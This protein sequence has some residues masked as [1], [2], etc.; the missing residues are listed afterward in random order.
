MRNPR[1]KTNKQV[2][3]L[4]DFSELLSCAS[5]NFQ[6]ACSTSQTYLT[7]RPILHTFHENIVLRK[8]LWEMMHRVIFKVLLSFYNLYYFLIRNTELLNTQSY[9]SWIE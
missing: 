7:M 3:L 1:Q 4:S 2:S 8:K 5:V 9:F 6:G